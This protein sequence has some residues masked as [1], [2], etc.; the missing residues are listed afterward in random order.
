[1]RPGTGGLLALVGS[2]SASF[3]WL[4]NVG[5]CTR[6]A[7]IIERTEHAATEMGHAQFR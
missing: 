3:N 1:M 7:P 6:L 5:C 2:C 4:K